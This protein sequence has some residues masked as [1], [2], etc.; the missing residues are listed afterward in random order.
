MSFSVNTDALP[1]L[2]QLM[3]RRRQALRDGYNYLQGN[4]TIGFLGEGIL[5]NLFGDHQQVVDAVGAFL[6]RAANDY[7]GRYST[8]VT[9]ATAYYRRTDASSAASLDASL[10]PLDDPGKHGPTSPPANQGLG[11][12][13][14]ADPPQGHVNHYVPPHDYQADYDYDFLPPDVLS[15]T[16]DAREF[17]W[18]ASKLLVDLGLLDHP[19]DIIEEA[20]KPLS[21]DWAAFGACR[22]V[23]KN[24]GD[25]L[26]DQAG[27]IHA[28]AKR[29]DLVW[30][31]NAADAC[32][33][34]LD[35]FGGDLN[36][37]SGT[38]FEIAQMYGHTA[39]EMKELGELLGSILTFV[40]DEAI[41]I[42][43]DAATDG[44][45]VA[46][47]I[48]NL[49]ED[50]IRGI[51]RSRGAIRLAWDIARKFIEAGKLTTDDIG[52]IGNDHPMPE[53]TG[54]VPNLPRVPVRAGTRGD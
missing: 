35:R 31:G 44:E 54:T 47:E 26:I 33:G 24:L 1:G 19:F 8:A 11:P 3:E 10:A 32:A 6:D 46:F 23:F 4:T 22:D 39:D 17:I 48:P 16:S 25:A 29:T 45:F 7:A 20:V 5:N 53:F 2:A 18:Q 50:F 42:C 30:T 40:L 37:A 14:F 34:G 13:V 12:D 49:V 41:D 9:A 36:R 51:Y 27:C 38:L 52:L 28:G 43:I 15:P 21:G